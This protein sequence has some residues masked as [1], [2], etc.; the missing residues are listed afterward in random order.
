MSYE[1]QDTL[2]VSDHET[3][4]F[5]AS[6]TVLKA[7]MLPDERIRL[8]LDGDCSAIAV[9]DVVENDSRVP[10]FVFENNK[11]VC[12]P[13]LR[14]SDNGPISIRHNTFDRI[15]GILVIDLLKYWYEAGAVDG[16][17][18]EDNLFTGTPQAGK[19]YAINIYSSRKKGTD[20]S[21]VNNRFV[22]PNTHAIIAAQVDGLVIRGNDFQG[23]TE[24]TML[25]ID[26]CTA[27][28][29]GDNQFDA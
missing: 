4:R 14:I 21:I 17:V 12:C 23:G 3:H 7:E 5:K 28:S 6:F 25:L 10:K 8:E 27:V 29:K 24:D 1:A 26:D 16:M 13:H 9:D 2:T 19:G 18:I 22:S 20:I 15:N 11:V